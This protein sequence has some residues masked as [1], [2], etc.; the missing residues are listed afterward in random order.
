MT[1]TISD[2]ELERKLTKIG[3]MQIV[4]VKKTSLAIAILEACTRDMRKPNLW[5]TLLEQPNHQTATAT[6]HGS[7]SSE[8]TNQHTGVSA[9]VGHSAIAGD[10]TGVTNPTAG[11]EPTS[12]HAVGTQT[13]TG[14]VQGSP[15][16]SVSNPPE[17]RRRVV[18]KALLDTHVADHKNNPSSDTT[19]INPPEGA[20]DA[21][22]HDQTVAGSYK[23][24]GSRKAEPASIN[25]A[26]LSGGGS[27]GSTT[28]AGSRTRPRKSKATR[29]SPGKTSKKSVAHSSV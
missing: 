25:D 20:G 12:D 3:Q 7:D 28:T 14:A 16:A 1:I 29:K 21:C 18:R 4:Q 8:P 27:P 23:Q 2:P 5:Q 15:A 17:G 6:E 19:A 24:S 10:S 11:G 9:P 22:S 13:T 26:C